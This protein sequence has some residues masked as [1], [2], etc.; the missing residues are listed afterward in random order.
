MRNC[1][2]TCKFRLEQKD[3]EQ[4]FVHD[5][6]KG[7]VRLALKAVSTKRNHYIEVS[8]RYLADISG[9]SSTKEGMVII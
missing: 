6:T 4:V 1:K 2:N 7:K 5:I 3:H 9:T 8:V